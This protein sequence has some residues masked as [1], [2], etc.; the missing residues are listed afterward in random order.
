MELTT[1][2]RGLKE[3]IRNIADENKKMVGIE[4]EGNTVSTM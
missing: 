1:A 3:Q 2:N 4:M